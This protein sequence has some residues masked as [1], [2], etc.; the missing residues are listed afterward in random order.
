MQQWPPSPMDKS[1]WGRCLLNHCW[2]MGRRSCRSKRRC[3]KRRFRN[4]HC[5]RDW[6]PCKPAWSSWRTSRPRSSHSCC[7]PVAAVCSRLRPSFPQQEVPFPA[8]SCCRGCCRS[9]PSY[10]TTP[11]CTK[12]QVTSTST[13]GSRWTGPQ[14]C[15]VTP[16]SHQSKPCKPQRRPKRRRESPRAGRPSALCSNWVWAALWAR[17]SASRACRRSTVPAGATSQG[18]WICRPW[19]S[20]T[21]CV[22][23]PVSGCICCRSTSPRGIAR[24]AG[25]HTWYLSQTRSPPPRP[26]KTTLFPPLRPSSRA[27]S[28]WSSGRPRFRL[29]LQAR[30]ANR[31]L[32]PQLRSTPQAAAPS[33]IPLAPRSARPGTPK[34]V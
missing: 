13:V 19:P 5:S 4:R 12:W 26:R 18:P 14:P 34:W 24:S 22:C 28:C 1:S 6:R 7:S 27:W 23:R 32:S 20:W 25:S 2:R 17:S 30:A 3:G 10:S 11:Q 8:R 31:T 33:W 15:W 9:R 21:V 16:R 29:A